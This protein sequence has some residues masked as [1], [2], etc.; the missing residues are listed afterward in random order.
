VGKSLRIITNGSPDYITIAEIVQGNLL[1]IGIN[2]EII[3]YDQATYFSLLM[4]ESNYDIAIFNPAAPSVMA[5][6]ILGMYLTF[7]P[8]GWHDAERDRY[9]EMSMKALATY[10][11]KARGDLIYE[12]LPIFL[13]NTPWYGLCEGV[14]MRAV[15]KD[16]QGIEYM[17]AGNAPFQDMY[18]NK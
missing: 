18:F 6:D 17:L 3:N 9:G 1:D 15:S 14:S 12:Y 11:P 16:L 10:D 7:I 2:S 8:L 13:D 4:D 5:V